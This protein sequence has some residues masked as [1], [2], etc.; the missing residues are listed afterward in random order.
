MFFQVRV[1]T[2][3]VYSSEYFLVVPHDTH[4]YIHTRG[5]IQLATYCRYRHIALTPTACWVVCRQPYSML[6]TLAT[7]V[8]ITHKH[9]QNTSIQSIHQSKFLAHNNSSSSNFLLA[10][11]AHVQSLVSVDG[12]SRTLKSHFSGENIQSRQ[13]VSWHRRGGD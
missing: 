13:A 8:A 6:R 4:T 3:V 11:S 5:M 7:A 1:F 12:L 2:V 9:A 10:F